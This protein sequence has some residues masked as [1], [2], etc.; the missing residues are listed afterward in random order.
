M[1]CSQRLIVCVNLSVRNSDIDS[2]LVSSELVTILLFYILYASPVKGN[3][4]GQSVSMLLSIRL[5][6]I[7]VVFEQNRVPIWRNKD[8][9]F[10]TRNCT[11]RY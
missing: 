3:N 9:A 4:G 10:I 2:V 11:T 6:V 8:S 1:L 5:L 7:R